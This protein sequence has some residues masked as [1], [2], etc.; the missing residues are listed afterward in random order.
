MSEEAKKALYW[1][2]AIILTLI[3]SLVAFY[4]SFWRNTPVYSLALVKTA[5]ENN[6]LVEFNRRVDLDRLL[7]SAYDDMADSLIEQSL[8]KSNLINLLKGKELAKQASRLAKSKVVDFAKKRIEQYVAG[9]GTDGDALVEKSGL[10]NVDFTF[11]DSLGFGAA[12]V[13]YTNIEGKKAIM[14]VRLY[15]RG[16]DTDFI[17]QL[18]MERVDGVW[19]LERIRNMREKHPRRAG[20]RFPVN[21]GQPK[22]RRNGMARCGI[23]AYGKRQWAGRNLPCLGEPSAGTRRDDRHSAAVLVDARTAQVGVTP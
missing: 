16:M 5:I 1:G 18:E 4:Y 22:R 6:D 3:L 14:G 11:F 20:Y 12:V 10:R 21:R 9:N 15:P 19:R 17:M 7:E 2:V 23:R 8:G 13:E